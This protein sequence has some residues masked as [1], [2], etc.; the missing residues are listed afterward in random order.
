MSNIT[1]ES[2]V[3]GSF[4]LDVKCQM[5]SQ[6]N[7]YLLSAEGEPS[8]VLTSPNHVKFAMELVGQGLDLPLYNISIISSSITV[9][10]NWLLE[11]KK[12][13]LIMLELG[14]SSIEFQNHIQ[15]IF[16][17]LSMVFRPRIISEGSHQQ[18]LPNLGP[19][20]K[21][22]DHFDDYISF[23]N[24]H[25]ELCDRVLT[26]HI[27]TTVKLHSSHFTQETWIVLLKV[28]LGICDTLLTQPLSRSTA[29]VPS[30]AAP[31]KYPEFHDREHVIGI[32]GDK[33]CE[34]LIKVY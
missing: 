20:T 9:Y 23:F 12:R 22:K 28:M 32:M 24:Q 27:L 18:G 19:T 26:Q 31:G 10:A 4:P 5:I 14:E 33:L 1:T 34:P 2:D 13:P 3:L 21:Q 29:P 8:E 7:K 25:I 16:K 11:P 30:S 6:M 17:H 15:D